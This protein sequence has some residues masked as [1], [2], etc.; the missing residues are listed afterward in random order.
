MS[1]LTLDIVK[2]RMFNEEAR[3]KEQGVA[4]ESKALVSECRE[5][6]SNR[7]LHKREKSKIRSKDDSRGRSKTRRDLEYYHCGRIGHMKRECM[8]F[9]REKDRGNKRS[10]ARDTTATTFGGNEDYLTMKDTLMSL[11]KGNGSLAKTSCLAQEKK[12]NT[13]YMTHAKVSNGYTNALAQ[14]SIQL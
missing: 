1:V 10:D 12:E 14:D 13:L 5:R 3:R 9:K 8:L 7:K 4:V 6:S 11:L 2:D